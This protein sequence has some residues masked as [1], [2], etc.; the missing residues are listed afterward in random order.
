[1]TLFK[2]RTTRAVLRIQPKFTTNCNYL[3]ATTVSQSTQSESGVTLSCIIYPI[4]QTWGRRPWEWEFLMEIYICFGDWS[5][6]SLEEIISK[7]SGTRKKKGLSTVEKRGGSVD[8]DVLQEECQESWSQF[9]HF[10]LPSISQPPTSSF[11]E[12]NQNYPF[13]RES[14]INVPLV[15][16][17]LLTS[18]CNSTCTLFL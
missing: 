9:L 12:F 7:G 11:S 8:V 4:S 15:L 10:F 17:S 18:T 6:V 13:Q 1:M 5:H 3:T 14:R 16:H 2:S